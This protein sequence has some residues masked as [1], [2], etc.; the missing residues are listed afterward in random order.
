MYMC[1][2]LHGEHLSTLKAFSLHV[3]A[4]TSD[5][6]RTRITQVAAMIGTIAVRTTIT[7]IYYIVGIVSALSAH[8]TFLTFHASCLAR[9]TVG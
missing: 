3:L 6:L 9:E 5:L 1:V 8:I 2:L 7:V 4:R